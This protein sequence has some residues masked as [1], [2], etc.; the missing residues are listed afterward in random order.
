MVLHKNGTS[1]IAHPACVESMLNNG[2]KEEAAKSK[3]SSKQENKKS[4]E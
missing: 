2:W 3:P 1:V 4:E